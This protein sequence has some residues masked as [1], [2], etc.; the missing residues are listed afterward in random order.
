[1]KRAAASLL[2]AAAAVGGCGQNMTDQPRYDPFEPAS[3]FENGR[4]LQA[5]RPGTVARGALQRQADATSKPA[6]SKDVLARGRSQYN[7]FCAPCHSRTGDGRGRIVQRGMP[8]PPSYHQDALR[9]AT[10]QHF[11]DVI[12]NGYGIMYAYAS[13]IS[14]RDRWAIIAYIRALQLSQ[15]ARLEDVPAAERSKLTPE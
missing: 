15:H 2:I 10:D 11:Y 9:N 13:R 5:P 4:V 1:M 7:V 3:L 8:Q 6:L 14:R 12:S